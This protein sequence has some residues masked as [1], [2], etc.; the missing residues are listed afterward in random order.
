M[1]NYTSPCR[2]LYQLSGHQALDTLISTWFGFIS[3]IRWRKNNTV[4]DRS[5]DNG[6]WT[7]NA[8]PTVCLFQNKVMFLLKI[9]L[10]NDKPLLN[11]LSPLSG[12]LQALVLRR[13]LLN[14]NSTVLNANF[15]T[16]HPKDEPLLALLFQKASLCGG[17][18]FSKPFPSCSKPL[19][20]S[21]AKC[22]AID[23]KT[24]VILIQ[25]KL[26]FTAKVLHLASFWKWEFLELGSGLFWFFFSQKRPYGISINFNWNPSCSTCLYFQMH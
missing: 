19:F 1:G 11:G 4:R 16:P 12:H 13:W 10:I 17:M 5:V 25:M 15:F 21:E 20:Q 8:S 3:R 2:Q 22:E 18:K 23:I 7:S 9:I 6:L 14:A 26:I 24:T